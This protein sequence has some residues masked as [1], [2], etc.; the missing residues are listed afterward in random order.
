[1]KRLYRR[2]GSFCGINETWLRYTNPWVRFAGVRKGWRMSKNNRDRHLCF[3]MMSESACLL[4]ET[5]RSH[6]SYPPKRSLSDSL[7]VLQPESEN[8][9]GYLHYAFCGDM[10]HNTYSIW[11]VGS[12]LNIGRLFMHACDGHFRSLQP[13]FF[14]F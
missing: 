14:N 8:L 1:M 6:H 10:L 7:N 3:S 5:D 2:A 4:M 13:C 11:H 12:L 9:K